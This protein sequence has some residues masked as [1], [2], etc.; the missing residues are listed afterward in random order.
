MQQSEEGEGCVGVDNAQ[1]RCG[2]LLTLLR[3]ISGKADM[4]G[5]EHWK[6]IIYQ[7][8]V[9]NLRRHDRDVTKA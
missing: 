9:R 3:T 2:R 5:Q 6:Y 8:A 7:V 4:E 1:D